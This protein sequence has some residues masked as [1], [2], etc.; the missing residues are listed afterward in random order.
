MLI[1]ERTKEQTADDY[2]IYRYDRCKC[3]HL[4]HLAEFIYNRETGEHFK[5]GETIGVCRG[6]PTLKECY[7]KG[8]EIKCDFYEEVREQARIRQ[9]S[10]KSIGDRIRN[11]KR[12]RDLARF[13][14]EVV[15]WT[16]NL[17][18]ETK[19]TCDERCQAH[20]AKWLGKETDETYDG[21]L[22]I[23]QPEDN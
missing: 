7:C 5:E 19:E 14:V 3:F 10:I 9:E 12:D 15:G 4:K 8:R 18:D 23:Q 22:K 11:L 21:I 16:C 2:E 1:H 20:C 17:C 6:T 13:L